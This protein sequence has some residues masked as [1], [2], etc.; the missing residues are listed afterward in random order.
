MY[1]NA[2]LVPTH[3]GTQEDMTETSRLADQV[4]VV[5]GMDGMVVYVP[6]PEDT[7]VSGGKLP[8]HLA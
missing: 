3:F 6:D 5:K 1:C 2:P 7:D 4:T 8:N